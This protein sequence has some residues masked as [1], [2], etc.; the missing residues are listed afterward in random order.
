[1]KILVVAYNY[2][3]KYC[4]AD[5][6]FVKMLVDEFARKGHECVVLAPHSVSHH[7]CLHHGIEEYAVGNNVVKVVRPNYISTSSL[8]IGKY[9]I[10]NELHKLVVRHALRHLKFKPD[11]VYC[12]FWKQASFSMNISLTTYILKNIL[13]LLYKS[14]RDLSK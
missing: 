9:Y 11:V 2:P 6:V 10:S 4:S 13:I 7:K 3:S 8:T 14:L 5:F 12:H 1:M